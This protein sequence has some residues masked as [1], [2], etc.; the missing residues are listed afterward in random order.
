MPGPLDAVSSRP[1]SEAERQVLDLILESQHGAI[2]SA[3]ILPLYAQLEPVSIDFMLGTWHGSLFNGQSGDGWWGKNMI[4]AD[5][6]Q[7]LL[8]QRPDG[9]VFSNEVWGLAKL[10]EGECYGL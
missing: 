8:F 7:P 10:T 3:R 1:V 6:V 2:D 4:S 5:H 9:S